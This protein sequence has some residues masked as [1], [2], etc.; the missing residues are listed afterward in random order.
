M[1]LEILFLFET[2]LRIAEVTGLKWIDIVDNRLYIRRQANNQG[3]K[4]K[5]KSMAGYRDIPL[6]RE[7]RRI[8][9]CFLQPLFV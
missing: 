5:T 6:T 3:V 8:L 2:G 7:A 4:E 9:D 1:G